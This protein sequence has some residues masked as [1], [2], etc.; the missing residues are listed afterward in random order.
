[1]TAVPLWWRTTCRLPDFANFL[2]ICYIKKLSNLYSKI[3]IDRGQV[4]I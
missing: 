4:E 1:M 3:L 2:K